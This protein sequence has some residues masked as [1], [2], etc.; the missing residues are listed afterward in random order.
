LSRLGCQSRAE[1]RP[2]PAALFAFGVLALGL[3][4]VIRGDFVHGWQPVPAW[5][6][7][8]E[9]IAYGSGVLMF[10]SGLGLFFRRTLVPASG[11]LTVYLLLWL[12]L[13]H[14]PIVAAAPLRE[15]NWE[16][17]AE[18]AVLAA[19]A[20]II[21]ASS[22]DESVNSRIGF[23]LGRRGTGF[24][25]VLFAAALLPIGLS[26]FVYAR[27]AIKLVPAWLPAPSAWVYVTGLAHIGAGT[28][29]LLGIRPRLAA[30]LEA[31]MLGAITAL[32]NV[33]RV[34]AAP[35][36]PHEWTWLSVDMTLAATAWLASD[37]LRDAPWLPIAWRR[38]P[39]EH[40]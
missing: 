11:I 32:V 9:A 37:A 7:W 39:P 26:H 6:R 27:E 14:G 30:A 25:A 31:G 21:L 15:D 19:G 34:A 1:T 33:P 40:V 4:G 16:I 28:G 24:A 38:R 8:R 12:L 17:S 29:V 23:A 3:L 5:L 20:W 13:L 2:L 18:T 10:A 35:T 22:T 36:N